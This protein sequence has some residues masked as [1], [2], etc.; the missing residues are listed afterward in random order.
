MGN[1]MNFLLLDKLVESENESLLKMMLFSPGLLGQNQAQSDQMT[2]LLPFIMM[3]SA[4]DD[5]SKVTGTPVFTR[6]EK[7]RIFRF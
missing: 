6:Y 4:D 2:S 7:Q 1:P 3:D 5:N